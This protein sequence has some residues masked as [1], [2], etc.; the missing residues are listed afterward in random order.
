MSSF[1]SSEFINLQIFDLNYFL[2]P[3]PCSPSAK[4]QTSTQPGDDLD[5]SEKAKELWE[6]NNE[7]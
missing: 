7:L 1:A 4:G 6:K 3:F 2:F 5:S